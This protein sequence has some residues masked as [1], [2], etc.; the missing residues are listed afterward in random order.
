[1]SISELSAIFVKNIRTHIYTHAV[2]LEIPT[3]KQQQQQNPKTQEGRAK[4]RE[5]VI[6]FLTMKVSGLYVSYKESY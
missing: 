5:T 1:M 4:M 3:D 6:C 2:H